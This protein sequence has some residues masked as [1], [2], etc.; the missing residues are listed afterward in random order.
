MKLY[1]IRLHPLSAWRTPWQADTL[2]GL[3]CLM[4]ART[5]S[6]QSLQEQIL[7]KCEQHSPPFVLSDAFP[8][9]LFPI[10]EFVRTQNWAVGNKQVKRARWLSIDSFKRLQNGKNLSENDLLQD[11]YFYDY[12]HTHNTLDRSTHTTG[13]DGSLFT[14][15]DTVMKNSADYLTVYARIEDDFVAQ[16]FTLFQELSN[17]GFGADVST[18]KGQFEILSSSFEL[19]ESLDAVEK[20]NSLISVS[21]FQPANS[22]PTLGLWEAFTKFGKF[23]PD[24]SL[25]NVFKKPLV[26]LRPGACFFTPTIKKILGRSIPMSE[27]NSECTIPLLHLAYSLALP[28]YLPELDSYLD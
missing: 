23:A 10:P 26:M 5:K 6:A 7:G 28:A 12:A 24:L 17:V 22:D 8:N 15:Q 3:L 14:L 18:G 20:P 16:L 13:D 25:E 4:M 11:N 19:T 21:T 9:D 2:S 1:K 27:L